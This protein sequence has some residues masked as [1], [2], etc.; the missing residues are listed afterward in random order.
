[1]FIEITEILCSLKGEFNEE[2]QIRVDAAFNPQNLQEC[3]E[4]A[5]YPAADLRERKYW[6]PVSRIDNAYGDRHLVCTCPAVDSY[7]EAA[8]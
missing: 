5:A 3:R 1:Q 7:R 4:E 8:E 2:H 6:P